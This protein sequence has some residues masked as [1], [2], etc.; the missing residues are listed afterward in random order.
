[1]SAP[2]VY[3]RQV[4][5][6]ARLTLEPLAPGHAAPMFAGFADPAL[7]AW[8]DVAPPPDADDLRQRFTRIARPYAPNG[9][10]WLNWAVRR[11][12]DARYVGLV[13]ATLRPDRV[14]YLAY[15]VFVPF[16]RQGIGREACAAVIEHLW[17]A[18]DAVEL[19]ADMD[20]RNV[21]SRLLVESLG[22]MRRKHNKATRLH[23]SP[24]VDYR[25]R[26]RRPDLR[27]TADDEALGE[28]PDDPES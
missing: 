14:G 2:L 16:A 4:L 12:E 1:V 27:R 6:T 17:R 21:P 26:L 20:F 25:Y 8:L 3:A 7:Y 10:L 11:T 22:F 24:S 28:S 18:Y 19:R 9:E 15:F 23:G 13:E 5:S